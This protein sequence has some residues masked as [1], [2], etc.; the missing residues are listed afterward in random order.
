MRFTCN[1]AVLA[2]MAGLVGQA[3]ASKSTK[4]IFECLRLDARDGEVEMVGTDLDVAVRYRLSEGVEVDEKGVAVVPASL[5]AGILREIADET[6]AVAVA[7]RKMTIET[8]GGHFELECE[9]EGQYPEIPEFP[10]EATGDIAAADLRALVRKT[11]FAAGREPARFVLNG[12]QLLAEAGDLRFVATDGR[13]LAT[14]VRPLD[15]PAKSEGRPVSAIVG[16][17]G[18]QHFERAVAS[19]DAAVQLAVTDRYVAVRTGKAEVTARVMDGAFPP[20]DQILPKECAGEATVPVGMLASRL[21]Q[22]GQ[23]ASAESQ[24][25]VVSFRE[26]E[27]GISAAGGSGRA[28]VRLGVEYDGPEEKI[29]FN[30]GFLL[31]ALKVVDGD[32]V[33]IGITNRNSAARLTDDGGLL[34]VVMPVL[35]D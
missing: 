5:F 23:F 6:V 28:D 21:R 4:R 35:I 15:R 8:D 7:K 1:R 18:L 2:E 14:V 33:R 32:K 30:P 13:R 20:Y 34:Y 9:D 17:K 29:G 16:V 24:S 27:I 25:V 19:A 26:G 31:D 12:V 3:V 11:A 22:V 10:K